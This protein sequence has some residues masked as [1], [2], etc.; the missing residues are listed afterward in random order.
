MSQR[1]LRNVINGESVAS[2]SDPTAL[3]NPTTGEVFAAAPNSSA[4]EVDSAY[5]AAALAFPSWRDST[6]AVRQKALLAIA[7]LLESHGQELVALESENTG[8]PIPV[9]MTEELPPMIDQIRFFAGA[10]RV[11]E[12]RSAGEYMA[13]FTSIIRREP[14][15]VIGQVTPWNY[16]M[17][18][19]VW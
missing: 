17:M 13:G 9:T 1:M 10:A 12:G 18:M 4:V 6:P 2:Q 15:G 11:L 3:V 19:A 14:V 16:P 7:D 5:Q 8:K